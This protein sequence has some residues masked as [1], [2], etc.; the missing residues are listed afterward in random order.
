MQEHDSIAD[1]VVGLRFLVDPHKTKLL[2]Q[3]LNYFIYKH[4][5]NR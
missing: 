5:T 2:I 3:N 1:S 4:N